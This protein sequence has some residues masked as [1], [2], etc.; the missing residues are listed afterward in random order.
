MLRIGFFPATDPPT[1]GLI[2]VEITSN[3]YK[4]KHELQVGSSK[5]DVQ[6]VL[7]WPQADVK[8]NKWS[9]SDE[10]YVVLEFTFDNDRV[11]QMEWASTWD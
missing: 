10:G 3:K 1:S 8:M 6:R 7:D 2:L 11:S 5:R 4:L 9:Y